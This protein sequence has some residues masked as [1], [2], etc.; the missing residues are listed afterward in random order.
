MAP[1]LRRSGIPVSSPFPLRV[2]HY[3]DREPISSPRLVKPS[4]RTSSTGLSCFASCQGLWDL[5]CQFD[6]PLRPTHPI[7]VE[8]PEF[9]I[10]PLLTPSLPAEALPLPGTHQMPPDLLLYPVFDKRK[11]SARMPHRKAVHPAPEDW[12]DQFDC[13]T[14]WLANCR[15][16]SLSFP[17]SAVRFLSFG[18]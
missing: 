3:P 15:N 16:A 13:P 12:I 4:V 10:Q 1:L 9:A 7:A 2:P 17:N 18:V 14:G 5:S 11:A 6:F 8:Q